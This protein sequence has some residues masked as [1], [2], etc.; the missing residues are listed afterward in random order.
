MIIQFLLI[1][2]ITYLGELISTLLNLQI[3]GTILGMLLM[4]FLLSTGIIKVK[5]IEKA[6]NILLINMAIFFLPPG[7]KLID[8][9]DNLKGSWL[10][11]IIIAVTTTLLTMVV[12]GKVVDFFIRRKK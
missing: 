6:A 11:L 2:G 7:I 5:Q 3:P 10:K 1:F 4:F 8:S 9:L 12:T